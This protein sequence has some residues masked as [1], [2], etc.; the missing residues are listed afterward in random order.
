VNIYS[1]ADPLKDLCINVLGLKREQCYGTDEQKN[2][3]TEYTWEKLSFFIPTG[4]FE[5]KGFKYDV[6]L[7]GTSVYP[8]Y[9]DEDYKKRLSAREIMQ[10]VGTNIFRKMFSEDVW[11]N[12]TINEIK[13]SEDDISLIADCR[14]P[15][16]ILSILNNEG[17]AIRLS[18]NV[19]KD[20]HESET[21]LDDFDWKIKNCILIENQ[22]LSEEE[23]NILVDKKLKE[24][25]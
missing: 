16:E 4:K 2:S 15:S 7:V 14:F 10:I 5:V 25:L 24:I 9:K 22:D 1:F 3:L 18:R 13:N 20:D 6:S 21:A 12:A 23:K 11:V 8:Y 17:L 19:Y